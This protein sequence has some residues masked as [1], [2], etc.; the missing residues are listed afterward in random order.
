MNV[1]VIKSAEQS[2]APNKS[3][4]RVCEKKCKEK[5]IKSSKNKR[6]RKKN[7]LALPFMFIL[8]CSKQNFF[9]VF[10]TMKREV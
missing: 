8:M 1:K 4:C 10:K 2:Q 9:F 3:F 7:I 5:K 6:K